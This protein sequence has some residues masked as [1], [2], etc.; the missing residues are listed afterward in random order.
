M[1]A[2]II[3][4]LPCVI[5]SFILTYISIPPIVRVSNAKH[6]FD[7]PN[8]RKLNKVVIPTLGGV[9]I[10]IG[11]SLSFIIFSKLGLNNEIKYIFAAVIM[12]F[13]IGLKD[14]ILVISAKKKFLVQLVATALLVFLGNVHLESFNGLFGLYEIPVWLGQITAFMIILFLTNALNLIDGIDGLASGI[15]LFVSLLFGSWFLMAGI[16]NY[17]ILCF[18]ISGSLIA[19][20][21]FNLWGKEN[22]IFMGD[23]GSLILGVLLAVIVIKFNNSGQILSSATGLLHI[24]AIALSL[25]IVPICDVLRV[26]T[27]RL[28]QK[29]SPFSPDMNHIHHALIKLGFTHIQSSAILISFTG[30]FVLAS[31]ILQN[32]INVTIS[33]L[34]LLSFS[35][36]LIWALSIFKNSYL[37]RKEKRL[38]LTRKIL[39]IGISPDEEKM[40][41]EFKNRRFLIFKRRA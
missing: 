30:T 19:F 22:K 36:G 10:F 7:K 33:F 8:H 23:T 32:Y 26:F 9:G 40:I 3:T 25:L 6:L 31:I 12:L 38:E 16:E 4:Y 29:R 37:S 34:S 14:D 27:I 39:T 13:F 15:A 5:V 17:A 11:L 18:S 2:T 21:K 20:L 1:E 28:L 24:P 41:E 35:F